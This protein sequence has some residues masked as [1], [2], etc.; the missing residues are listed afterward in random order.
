SASGRGALSG[1]SAAMGKKTNN[2]PV[3]KKKLKHANN[4]QFQSRGGLGSRRAKGR[5]S[6]RR[7]R[8]AEQMAL[9]KGVPAQLEAAPKA[10]EAER[11]LL[12]LA[13]AQ[14]DR[15]ACEDPEAPLSRTARKK[16]RIAARKA[17]ARHEEKRRSEA[18]LE[19][20]HLPGAGIRQGTVQFADDAGEDA[21]PGG[22]SGGARAQAAAS[23]GARPR[24]SAGPWGALLQRGCLL[25]GASVVLVGLQGAAELNGRLATCARWD[26][27]RARWLVRLEGGT[28]KLLRPENVELNT[29][30]APVLWA[31]AQGRRVPGAARR[32][33]NAAQHAGRVPAGGFVTA[34]EAE[35]AWAAGGPRL[36]ARL[37]CLADA[38]ADAEVAERSLTV[39]LGGRLCDDVVDVGSVR[40]AGE[41]G[42]AW[43]APGTWQAVDPEAEAKV[44]AEGIAAGWRLA[45]LEKGAPW[46]LV[47]GGRLF[48]WDGHQQHKKQAVA[49]RWAARWRRRAESSQGAGLMQKVRARA[50]H[51]ALRRELDAEIALNHHI[52]ELWRK[53]TRQATSM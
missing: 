46:D 5:E 43:L 6:K 36:D 13:K 32:R 41:G 40:S 28:E 52:K 15:A 38:R 47:R 29:G 30:T 21:A 11:D 18:E 26:D 17:E 33:R 23:S 22:G 1:C 39:E 4:F 34:S 3:R 37:L 48:E 16:R 2:M 14:E 19:R 10:E 8:L 49:K 20:S 7:E 35:L 42:S 31:G 9:E 12:D 51:L 53:H 44:F 24:G 27:G 45:G 25:P 50:D